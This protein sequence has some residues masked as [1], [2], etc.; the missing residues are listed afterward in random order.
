MATF[1]KVVGTLAAFAVVATLAPMSASAASVDKAAVKATAEASYATDRVL[2]KV[3]AGKDAKAV[4]EKHAG[5]LEKALG[6][7]KSEWKLVKVKNADE[8]KAKFS[9]DAD[10]EAVEFDYIRHTMAT[11]NDPSYASQYHLPKIQANLAWDITKGTTARTIAIIDTGIDLQHTDLSGKIVAGYDFVNYDTNA[12]DDQGHGTHCAGIAAAST[13]NA[14]NVA[15]VDWYAKLMPVKVLDA[16]GS[17]YDSDIIDGIYYAADNG[18]HVLSMSLGGG[19]YSQASQDAINYA[20]N[21]KGRIIVAAAGNENTS[22]K[23]YPAAYA[24]V[25]SVASTTSTDARSSFSNYGTWVDVAA[26]GSSIL[27]TRNGGGTTTMSGTSM[28]TP[29]VAGLASLAWSKNTAYSNTTVV[30]RIFNTTDRITG[31]GT[32]WY[33]GRVNAYKAVNGF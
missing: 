9:V 33:Y 11:P 10:V 7:G 27:A 12:D 32:Y 23:S 22:A 8:A 5:K 24:N 4:A 1:N 2:V 14:L 30:N 20:Y 15:G 13:N 19:G 31:T 16:A 6:N 29:V 25:I 28:A 26:P 21:T 18:A 3:K 17:G